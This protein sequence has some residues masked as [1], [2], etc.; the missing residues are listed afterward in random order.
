MERNVQFE[1]TSLKDIVVHLAWAQLEIFADDVEKIQVMAAGDD[2]SVSDLRIGIKDQTLL[3]EQSQYGISL[4]ITESRW[5]QVCIRVPRMWKKELYINTI[6]SLLSARGLSGSKIVLDTISGDLRASRIHC[7]NLS[8]KTISGDVRAQSLHADTLSVRSVSGGVVLDDLM[9]QT[10]KCNSVSGEQIYNLQQGF[11]RID[12]NAVSG[13]VIITS[14]LDKVN[15]GI[16]SIS[17][18]VK[19][20]GVRNTEVEGIP[21]VRVTG[22]T[23]DLKLICISQPNNDTEE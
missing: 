7:S 21:T 5:M 16:R 2:T 4:N 13:D 15:A 11:R 17:G 23:A 14:P 1:T 20:V 8:L 6:T 12:I 18:T 3:V 9:V 10:L 22:I 19:L